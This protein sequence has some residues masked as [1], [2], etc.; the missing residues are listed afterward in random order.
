V[1]FHSL[2]TVQG[3]L[4]AAT[5]AAFAVSPGMLGPLE[6][7]IYGYNFTL[8]GVGV[9]DPN[10]PWVQ[11]N[12]LEYSSCHQH[13]HF[14]H[15]GTFQYGGLPGSKKAFCLEDT[16]RTHNDEQTLLTPNHQSCQFQ[17]I[18]AGWGD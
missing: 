8:D 17:G 4:A 2:A 1:G 9:V 3:L 13:Y 15:Y 11:A 18:A 5:K 10:N 16:D 7:D 12:V 14:S 6:P